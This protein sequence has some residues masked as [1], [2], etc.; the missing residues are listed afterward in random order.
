MLRQ[1]GTRLKHKRN[2]F[3]GNYALAGAWQ[4]LAFEL[5]WSARAEVCRLSIPGVPSQLAMRRG[6]SDPDVFSSIFVERDL[7]H[8]L[9]GDARLVID[10]GANV[11]FSSVFYACRYPEALVIAVE[12]DRDN[13]ELA[14]RNCAGLNVR[15]VEGAVWPRT[16]W[17]RIANP[18][19]E[20]WAFRVEECGQRDRGAVR[21]WSIADLLADSGRD[22]C[23]LLKMDIEGGEAD[24]FA[25]ECD[26]LPRV[27][28]IV[29]D[30]HGERAERAVMARTAA[31]FAATRRGAQLFLTPSS[32]D[33]PA[34]S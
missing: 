12:P 15:V 9:P 24:V 3:L 25:A 21:A 30:L 1:L 20:P 27:G 31:G 8:G 18:D 29:I 16:G 5:A 7:E 34:A 28:Q 23:D 4:A 14:R 17:V 6:T 32:G 33:R 13:A 11:G 10:A 22:R 26:W 2:R 19:A